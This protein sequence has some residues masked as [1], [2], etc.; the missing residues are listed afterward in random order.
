MLLLL[1][2]ASLPA[3]TIKNLNVKQRTWARNRAHMEKTNN[4][5]RPM[6]AHPSHSMHGIRFVQPS[7]VQNTK[8]K[9]TMWRPPRSP[10][11]MLLQAEIH[12]PVHRSPVVVFTCSSGYLL[13]PAWTIVGDITIHPVKAWFRW[14]SNPEMNQTTNPFPHPGPLLLH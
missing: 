10:S 11:W 7:L 9:S 3:S 8:S 1:L 4:H 13:S 14:L 5:L 6:A 2:L 12:L